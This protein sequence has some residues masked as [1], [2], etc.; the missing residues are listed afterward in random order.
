MVT[1]GLAYTYRYVDVPTCEVRRVVLVL[2][3]TRRE[4]RLARV[5]AP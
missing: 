2:L 4:K 5:L 1:N 3:A